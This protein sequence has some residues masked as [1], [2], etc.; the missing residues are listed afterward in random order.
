MVA[1]S[2]KLGEEFIINIIYTTIQ[3]PAIRNIEV[4]D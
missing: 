2:K 4:K 1:N 3:M